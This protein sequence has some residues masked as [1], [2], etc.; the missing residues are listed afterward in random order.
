M[1]YRNNFK[2]LDKRTQSQLGEPPQDISGNIKKNIRFFHLFGDII[3][4]FFPKVIS[5]FTDML[6]GSNDRKSEY[7]DYA[8]PPNL[9]NK[10]P[11]N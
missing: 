2:E 4:L 9:L 10:N 11:K 6:G 5:I 8:K 3:D 7:E 1:E